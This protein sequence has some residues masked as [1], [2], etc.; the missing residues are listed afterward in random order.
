MPTLLWRM[1]SRPKAFTAASVAARTS[2]S[3]V[4]FALT[5]IA[6]PPSPLMMLGR[7]LR[8]RLV[9]VDADDLGA[10][11]R[12][13]DRARLAVPPALA[14]RARAVDDRDA[15]LKLALH[16]CPPIRTFLQCPRMPPAAG[17]TAPY[18][19][20]A[21]ALQRR[22]RHAQRALTL[23]ENPCQRR[24][25]PV[26]PFPC[27]AALASPRST[28]SP[29]DRIVSGRTARWFRRARRDG[30]PDGPQPPQGRL[31]PHRS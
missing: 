27:A 7:R 16:A 5:A 24:S 19:D 23:F 21:A 6:S 1:S 13:G 30:P 31:R 12:I 29:Q 17:E 20:R 18:R 2:S 22:L 26:R 28:I 9:H 8:R 15:I 11:A 14:D 4:T 25:L 10:G 3:P